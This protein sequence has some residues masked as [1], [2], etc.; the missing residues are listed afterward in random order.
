VHNVLY[1]AEDGDCSIDNGKRVL[2]YGLI[3]HTAE[4]KLTSTIRALVSNSVLAQFAGVNTGSLSGCS[5]R[6]AIH[7]DSYGLGEV[8]IVIV[9]GIRDRNTPEFRI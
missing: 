3:V 8:T 5:V 9:K 6:N 2:A 1:R 7:N 4:T